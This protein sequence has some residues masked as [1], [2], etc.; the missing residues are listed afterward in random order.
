MATINPTKIL[1]GFIV[2][3]LITTFVL[4]VLDV[5]IWP[6][7]I[8]CGPACVDDNIAEITGQIERSAFGIVLGDEN[9][10]CLKA[11]ESILAEELV[12]ASTADRVVFT[13]E[14][15][16]CGSVNVSETGITAEEEVFF[17]TSTRCSQV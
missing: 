1:E 14:G 6:E 10:I 15:Y 2:G 12:N 8:S 4:V 9:N 7:K 13:C 3:A 11:G 16:I 17:K 5:I